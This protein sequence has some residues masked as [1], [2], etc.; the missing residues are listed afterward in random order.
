MQQQ[1][2]SK[3][4]KESLTYLDLQMVMRIQ[5]HLS[6]KDIVAN[7]VKAMKHYKDK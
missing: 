7:F 4:R 6:R 1:T 5:I 2:L 3:K